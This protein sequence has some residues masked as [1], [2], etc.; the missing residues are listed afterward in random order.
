M[1][2]VVP[3]LPVIAGVVGAASTV[4][5]TIG[6]VMT[7]KAGGENARSE[8]QTQA[9]VFAYNQRI[10]EMNAEQARTAAAIQEQQYRKKAE[11]VMATNRAAYAKAGV[12]MEGSPLMVAE[13]NAAQAEFDALNLRY[14]GE[15]AA[16]NNLNQANFYGLY[17]QSALRAG[18]VGS[19]MAGRAAGTTL[20]TSGLKVAMQGL[21]YAKQNTTSS[22]PGVI[23]VPTYGYFGPAGYGTETE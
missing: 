2:A 6:Q 10:A 7:Q 4:A 19:K 17:G 8:A 21:N 3:F 22:N 1:S 20:L 5:G 15:L 12:T 13:E 23:T 18:E 14:Q 16:W 11:A 9:S